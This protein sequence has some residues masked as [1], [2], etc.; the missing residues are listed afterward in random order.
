MKFKIGDLVERIKLLPGVEEYP[1]G[2]LGVVEDVS[3]TNRGEAWR[4]DVL[5]NGS[6]GTWGCRPDT[7]RVIPDETEEI[8]LSCADL[9]EVL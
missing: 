2:S 5:F 8:S 9:A 1:V 3:L 7:L 4:V 6:L